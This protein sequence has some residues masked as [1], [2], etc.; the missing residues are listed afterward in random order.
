MQFRNVVFTFNNYSE[1]E[2]N[3]ILALDIFKYLVV[4]KE[5]GEQGTKHLQCYG[6]LKNRMVDN[7][8]RRLLKGCHI[9]PRRGT[10]Q[11]ASEYCKKGNEFV[12]IGE[13]PKQGKRSD[14]EE[15]IDKL[16]SGVSTTTIC[17]ENTAC[18]IKYFRGIEQAALKLQ[19]PYEHDSVRGIWV[20]GPPGTGK[21]W[22]VRQQFPGAYLKAQNKWW[23]GYNGQEAVILDDL[24]TNVLGHYLK[25]WSDRYACTGETKGGTVHL[26]HRYFIVTSNQHPLSLFPVEKETDSLYEAIVRRFN[27]Y[28]KNSL[29]DNFS[30]CLPV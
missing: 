8:L 20:W 9:E 6:T 27:V 29:N 18:Y 10:H 24:D 28:E 26:R 7:K 4:G 2:Y 14:L 13:P 25:I 19:Q 17:Q 22:S 15:V 21:S 5:V 23:D 11:Q 1:D 12:E 3:Y 16:K 30:Y